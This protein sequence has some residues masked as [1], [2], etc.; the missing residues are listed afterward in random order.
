[1]IAGPCRSIPLRKTRSSF[2]VTASDS[3]GGMVVCAASGT[4]QSRPGCSSLT[5]QAQGSPMASS[6][7]DFFPIS[8]SACLFITKLTPLPQTSPKSCRSFLVSI[9]RAERASPVPPVGPVPGPAPDCE[10]CWTSPWFRTSAITRLWKI[11]LPELQGGSNAS[12]GDGFAAPSRREG[13]AAGLG[14]RLSAK[15]TM[16]HDTPRKM[17]LMPTSTPMIVSPDIGSSRQI[18]TPRTTSIAPLSNSQPQPS[19]R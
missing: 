3:T 1:M 12:S 4:P 17:M 11:S 5:E 19:N 8:H 9:H 2:N 10:L 14:S 6:P 18:I 16:S 15:P 7:C 13:Q